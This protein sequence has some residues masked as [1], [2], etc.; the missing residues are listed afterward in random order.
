MTASISTTITQRIDSRPLTTDADWWRV[1]QLLIDTYPI[2][3]LDFNW[4]IRRWDGSRFHRQPG[5]WA[6]HLDGRYQLW[7][8]GDG[9]LVGVAHPEGQG[10]AFLELHPDY[11]FLEAEMLAWAEQ[12]LT[13][14]TEDGQRRELQ[15]FVYE[16]DVQRRHLLE[17]LG[18]EKMPWSGVIRRLRFGSQPLPTVNIAPGYTLR[19]TRPD[20]ADYQRIADILNAGFNRT[21]HTA[22]EVRNFMTQAP[23]FRH[24]LDLVAEAP[25]GSFASYVGV[26]YDEANRHGIFEP[27]CT[28]PDHRKKGLA[29]ALMFEGLHRLKALGCAEVCVGT[30]EAV[31]ANALYDSVGFT[32]IYQGHIWRKLL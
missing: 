20:D 9:Q 23:S 19:T 21:I 6:A 7:E 13:C 12:H 14:P 25:D 32:E 1:R 5:E 30:G 16:Y 29:Q 28:H 26:I 18:Y 17:R 11:R 22:M 27:V 2:T 24:D 4:E 15:I 3:P 10:D 31:A 8:T